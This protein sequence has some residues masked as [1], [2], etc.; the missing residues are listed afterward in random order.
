MPEPFWFAS[1]LIDA[2][3]HC[4]GRF[5]RAAG[6]DSRAVP[7]EL[8]DQGEASTAAIFQAASDPTQDGADAATVAWMSPASPTAPAAG[9]RVAFSRREFAD[10]GRDPLANAPAT[11]PWIVL[12]S[13]EGLPAAA[14]ADSLID[15]GHLLF[16]HPAA[17]RSN[18]GATR[19]LSLLTLVS[20]DAETRELETLFRAEPE[21]T[22][23]LLRLVNSVGGGMRQPISSLG[24]AI[25]V[26]GRRQ[27]KRWL[28]LL[29][30][31]DLD[32]R[33]GAGN[34]LLQLAAYRGALLERLAPAIDD[35][36]YMVGIFSLLDRLLPKSMAEIVAYLPLG[37][38]AREA[39]AVRA[40]PLGRLLTA[41]DAADTG[42][43]D[44]AAGH[45]TAADIA[46]R[47][48]HLGQAAAYRFAAQ[49][50]ETP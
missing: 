37:P 28:Q 12:D 11:A 27:L 45:L 25:T 19:V 26:L 48:W 34:P 41:F 43:L 42:R 6:G 17:T 10:A 22:Y 13:A 29:L 32:D 5:L 35:T 16:V 4:S 39:L 33:R 23:H 2:A 46:P 14:P 7:A 31:A 3:G 44:A 8:A 21:L 24:H 38:A 18:V 30:Y 1:I 9:K 40:G 20:R 50:G 36:S 47:A 15:V 49:L